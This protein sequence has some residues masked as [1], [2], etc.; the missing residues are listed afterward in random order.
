MG[1]SLFSTISFGF[2]D[3]IIFYANRTTDFKLND[4][5][6][7][8]NSHRA[9]ILAKLG[10]PVSFVAPILSIVEVHERPSVPLYIET[11]SAFGR[12]KAFDLGHV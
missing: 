5:P 3:R 12:K 8:P 10:L 9:V 2:L 7:I 4:L 6:P 11:G 1:Y